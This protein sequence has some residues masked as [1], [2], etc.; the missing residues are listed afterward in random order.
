MD[1]EYDA[2]EEAADA[3]LA[4]RA[5]RTLA[6]EGDGPRATLAEVLADIRGAAVATTPPA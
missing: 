1:T 5:L 6:D 2:L 4:R 3:A